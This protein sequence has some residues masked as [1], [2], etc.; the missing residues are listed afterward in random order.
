[1]LRA[2]VGEPAAGNGLALFRPDAEAVAQ[3]H[4]VV[5]EDVDVAGVMP[6]AAR[7]DVVAEA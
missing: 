6:V 1:V 2:G 5:V 4:R 3:P 7:E